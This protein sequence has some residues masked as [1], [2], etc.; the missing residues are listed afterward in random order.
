VDRGWIGAGKE[1]GSDQGRSRRRSWGRGRRGWAAAHA[2]AAG[3]ALRCAWRPEHLHGT[4]AGADVAWSPRG[5]I[6]HPSVSWYR[7][8]RLGC[9]VGNDG[10]SYRKHAAPHVTPILAER[11]SRGPQ[12]RA[13]ARAASAGVSTSCDARGMGAHAWGC[14]PIAQDAARGSRDPFYL[15]LSVDA[16]RAEQVG[17]PPSPP[18]TSF[19]SA[20]APPRTCS[21]WPCGDISN[22]AGCCPSEDVTLE[23]TSVGAPDIAAVRRCYRSITTR[24]RWEGHGQSELAVCVRRWWVLCVPCQQRELRCGGRA[25]TWEGCPQRHHLPDVGLQLRPHRHVSF[26]LCVR[27]RVCCTACETVMSAM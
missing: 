13:A 1:V 14:R 9:M 16:V 24:P 20:T 11:S 17:L 18:D 6:K 8:C 5:C 23:P 27:D 25:S 12:R 4:G 3:C 21:R 22:A 26:P 10:A 19:A 2:S 15:H 7:R